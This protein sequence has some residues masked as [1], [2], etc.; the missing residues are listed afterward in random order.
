MSTV[1]GTFTE[2]SEGKTRFVD[3]EVSD[4]AKDRG[5]THSVETIDGLRPIK[6]LKTVCY[7]MVDEDA[8]GNAVWAKWLIKDLSEGLVV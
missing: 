8:E 4:W 5:A 3:S 2:K 1:I 7:V 6:L